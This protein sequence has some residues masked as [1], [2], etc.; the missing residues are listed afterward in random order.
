MDSKK[1][2]KEQSQRPP[3]RE[4]QK[5]EDQSADQANLLEKQAT[6][7]AQD[8]TLLAWLVGLVLFVSFVLKIQ[9]FKKAGTYHESTTVV[10]DSAHLA[11]ATRDLRN[12]F[13]LT[14]LLLFDDDRIQRDSV[15]KVVGRHFDEGLTRSPAVEATHFVGCLVRLVDGDCMRFVAVHLCRD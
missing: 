14:S 2:K 6:A 4:A 11:V 12:P 9:K 8:R 7:C 15:F 13:R 3:Q 10:L 5:E 1:R